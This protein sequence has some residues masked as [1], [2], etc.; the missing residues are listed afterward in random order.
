MPEV[1]EIL[2]SNG[3]PDHAVRIEGEPKV[4]VDDDFGEGDK[5]LGA[6]IRFPKALERC[7]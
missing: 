4:R 7:L 3:H 2:V 6:A 5:M 1:E